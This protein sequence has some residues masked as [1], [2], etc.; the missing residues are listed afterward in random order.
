MIKVFIDGNQGTTGLEIKERLAVRDDIKLITLKDE[1]RKNLS[2]RADSINESDVTFLCL[3]DEAAVESVGL[4]K[5]ENT[6]IID[7]S[8]AHRTN[9]D[10]AYGFPELGNSFRQ[11][12]QKSKRI[13]VPGCHASGFA[14]LIYPL[15]KLG[16]IDKNYPIT[17]YSLTGYS[18]G[19]KKMI[20]E[21][22]AENNNYTAPRMYA[23]EQNHKHLK[24]MQYV[25]GL[26]KP[27]LF[28]PVVCNYYKGMLVSVGLFAD[29]LN[30]ITSAKELQSILKEYYD[31]QKF[32]S[33]LDSDEVKA[34]QADMIKGKNDMH[35]F[36]TGNDE[37]IVLSAVFDNLGKGASGAAV[38]CMNIASNLP[39][40]YLL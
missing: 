26:N 21:Y 19:G 25:S 33:V 30:G 16:I 28:T 10:W 39:E 9:K 35:L 31:N 11:A 7:A 14:A 22:Q 36:V 3:P 18:G 4:V 32:V 37:R 1:Y 27:P 40:D 13:A 2:A 15:I 23:L 29:M 5:N 34:I 20:A 24:E 12:I 8:T 6:K 38:Q 17:C